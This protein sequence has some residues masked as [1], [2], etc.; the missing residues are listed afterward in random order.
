M[1]QPTSRG[2]STA[3]AEDYR[4]ADRR[5]SARTGAPRPEAAE[6]P[7]PEGN[8]DPSPARRSPLSVLHALRTSGR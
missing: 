5:G 7:R 4:S 2:R 6:L 8:P 1:L 3:F